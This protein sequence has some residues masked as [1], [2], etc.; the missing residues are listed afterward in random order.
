MMN[1]NHILKDFNDKAKTKTSV[2][3]LHKPLPQNIFILDKNISQFNPFKNQEI[4]CG[5]TSMKLIDTWKEG[6]ALI[7]FEFQPNGEG[8]HR[9]DKLCVTCDTVLFLVNEIAP[10]IMKLNSKH[11]LTMGK[12][13][14]MVNLPLP[15]SN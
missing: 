14:N 6:T 12:I 5:T 15:S 7:I 8:S 11:Q 4:I 13:F 1:L 9:K 2:N 3:Q 10:L